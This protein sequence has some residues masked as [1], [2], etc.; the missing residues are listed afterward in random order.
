MFL[1]VLLF[2]LCFCLFCCWSVLGVSFSLVFFGWGG[3]FLVVCFVCLC[4]SVFVFFVF[5]CFG[6]LVFV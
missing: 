3:I 6:G 4:W 1:F 2:L 5:L